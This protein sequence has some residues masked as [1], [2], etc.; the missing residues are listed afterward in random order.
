MDLEDICE[1]I[2]FVF[3]RKLT[4]MMCIYKL[5]IMHSKGIR[6][7]EIF[8]ILKY[9]P[10]KK[11]QFASKVIKGWSQKEKDEI[12]ALMRELETPFKALLSYCESV[13]R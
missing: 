9:S 12:T 10:A 2:G 5:Y 1:N 6:L 3:T 8:D 11:K 13:K 4:E 7:E